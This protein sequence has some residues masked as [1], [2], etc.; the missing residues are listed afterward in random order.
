MKGTYVLEH[1]ERKRFKVKQSLQNTKQIQ[2]TET[3]KLSN[4]AG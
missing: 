3:Q 4:L 2:T 1:T